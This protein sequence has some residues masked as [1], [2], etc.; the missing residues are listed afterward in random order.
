MAQHH[1]AHQHHMHQVDWARIHKFNIT[2]IV[3][4]LSFG[5]AIPNYVCKGL[6]ERRGRSVGEGGEAREDIVLLTSHYR[7][8]RLMAT[9]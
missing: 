4:S 3:N 2:H 9:K 1:E 8:T 7:S 5:P 6:R